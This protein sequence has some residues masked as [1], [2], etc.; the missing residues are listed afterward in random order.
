MDDTKP[1]VL[2][3]VG[4]NASGKSSLGVSIS[5]MV[6]GEVISADSRQI[7]KRLN[8]GSGK[9]TVPEMQG[10]PH[11][12]IDV[13]EPG[14]IYSLFDYQREAYASIDQVVLNGNTPVL[15]GGTG[16]YINAVIDGYR[17]VDAPPNLELRTQLEHETVDGLRSKL[18]KIQP[19]SVSLVDMN[20]PRRMI[21]AIEV[22]SAGF[23]VAETRI[24]SP[25]FNAS[26]IG[27]Y[28][29]R[30]ELR[31]RIRERMHTRF[32]L[33]MIEEVEEL[34]LSGVPRQFL[35]D[36]GLEYR[37]ITQYIDGEFESFEQFEERLFF[38]ICQFAKRQY[39]WFRK[40]KSINWFHGE[41]M[42]VEDVFDTFQRSSAEVFPVLPNE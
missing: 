37:I 7:Y 14:C 31:K 6:S 3:I 10:V 24:K 36:I 34:I 16:L 19:E 28:W 20:N 1:I 5:Q 33:G 12:M 39:T 41:N 25:R 42:K 17:L 22:A 18:M 29:D 13:A 15:V 32:K 4:A 40:D 38:A 9:I 30:D 8:L 23:S 27:V 35:F 26:K 2:C 11:W 21:R